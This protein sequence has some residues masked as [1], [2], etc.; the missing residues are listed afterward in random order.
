MLK[1]V[2]PVSNICQKSKSSKTEYMYK[3]IHIDNMGFNQYKM[4][5]LI[6]DNNAVML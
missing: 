3:L 5:S 6:R 1:S 2:H 4:K